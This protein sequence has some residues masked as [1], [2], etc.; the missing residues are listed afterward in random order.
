MFVS[1]SILHY[2][3]HGLLGNESP[4][5]RDALCTT[6]GT[7]AIMRKQGLIR[8]YKCQPLAD[9]VESI[10]I[11]LLSSKNVRLLLKMFCALRSDK[12]R[13]LSVS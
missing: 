9:V 11:R 13:M 7:N 1:V 3:C 8:K 5:G 4:S 12:E 6:F 2:K 10:I